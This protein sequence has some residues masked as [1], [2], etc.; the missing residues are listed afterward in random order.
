VKNVKVQVKKDFV[1]S[2]PVL[3]KLY[4]IP[5]EALIGQWESAPYVME[6]GVHLFALAGRVME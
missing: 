5:K 4:R 2:V 1:Q 3:G 6:V